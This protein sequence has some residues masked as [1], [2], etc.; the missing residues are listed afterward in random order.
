[1][2]QCH[3][4]VDGVGPR[5]G[6]V[7]SNHKQHVDAPTLTQPP[8]Q[9]PGHRSGY[10]PPPSHPSTISRPT[11]LPLLF[12]S[13]ESTISDVLAPPLETPSREPPMRCTLA[14]MSR[15]NC[16]GRGGVRMLRPTFL[17]CPLCTL[18]VYHHVRSG[19]V[20]ESSIPVSDPP[21]FLHSVRIQS[22]HDLPPSTQ[23]TRSQLLPA[24]RPLCH[25]SP[26]PP[27]PV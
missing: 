17:P 13:S 2:R 18:P 11:P 25:L 8:P 21:D 14:T 20:E 26:F 19:F 12:T 24:M 5:M 22:H 23:T 27:P 1:M 6:S 7:S 15:V 10:H 9:P 16:G 4:H 3:L